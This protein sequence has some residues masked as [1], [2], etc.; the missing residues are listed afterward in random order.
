MPKD[1]LRSPITAVNTTK[2]YIFLETSTRPPSHAGSWFDE[3]TCTLAYASLWSFATCRQR[4]RWTCQRGRC[5]GRARTQTRQ[6]MDLWW[7]WNGRCW[8]W[9]WRRGRWRWQRQLEWQRWIAYVE[10]MMR[11]WRWWWRNFR[12]FL[13]KIERAINSIKMSSQSL[14]LLTICMV[15]QYSTR[16]HR[17]D[18]RPQMTCVRRWRRWWRWCHKHRSSSSLNRYQTAVKTIFMVS[19]KNVGHIDSKMMRK[20]G[21]QWRPLIREINK[22]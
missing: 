8:S 15:L 3:T 11:E 9:W 12:K 14:K 6:L 1:S 20:L 19:L 13:H 21:D 4:W 5:T 18:T 16:T 7:R 22:C 2:G 17:D 10:S